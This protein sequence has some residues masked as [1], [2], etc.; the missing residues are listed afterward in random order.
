MVREGTE[1]SRVTGTKENMGLGLED[2]P[3]LPQGRELNPGYTRSGLQRVLR[4]VA[5]THSKRQ[6][7]SCP[8]VRCS[9]PMPSSY[10]WSG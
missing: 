2:R 5:P 6:E 3:W 9:H 7:Q 4:T 8:A 10:R 1:K